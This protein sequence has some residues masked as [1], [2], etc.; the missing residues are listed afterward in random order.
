[1]SQLQECF[2]AMRIK[3]VPCCSN[4]LCALITPSWCTCTISILSSVKPRYNWHDLLKLA[5]SKAIYTGWAII[6]APTLNRFRIVN[7]ISLSIH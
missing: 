3:N 1:M 2:I 4:Q 6:S 7:E 5:H